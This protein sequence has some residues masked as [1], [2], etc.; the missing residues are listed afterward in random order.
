MILNICPGF[1]STKK[2]YHKLTFF[3]RFWETDT[4]YSIYIK[5][6]KNF[7]WITYVSIICYSSMLLIF[8]EDKIMYYT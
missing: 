8:V 6:M 2:Y 7:N 3:I 4:V 5:V 1:I